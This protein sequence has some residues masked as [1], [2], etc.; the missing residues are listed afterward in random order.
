MKYINQNNQFNSEDFT[1]IQKIKLFFALHNGFIIEYNLFPLFQKFNLI[2]FKKN[3]KKIN[4][5]R[6]SRVK[7]IN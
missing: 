5:F 3:E 6:F 7:F 2:K 4:F 1:E